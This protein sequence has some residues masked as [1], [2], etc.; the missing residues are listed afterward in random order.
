MHA[1]GSLQSVQAC[2]PGEGLLLLHQAVQQ[3]TCIAGQLIQPLHEALHLPAVLACMQR[4]SSSPA[5]TPS[6]IVMDL[7][8]RSACGVS[9]QCCSLPLQPAGCCRLPPCASLKALVEYIKDTEH[10]TP[11]FC[12]L[13]YC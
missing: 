3:A 12:S 9:E 1:S 4:G 8:L 7:C 6:E 11:P 2:F 10:S 5:H 13:L